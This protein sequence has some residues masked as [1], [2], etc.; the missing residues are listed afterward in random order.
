MK[1][2][3]SILISYLFLMASCVKMEEVHQKYIPDG[4][5]IYRVKPRHVVSYSGNNRAKLTWQLLYPTLVTKCEIRDKDSVLVEIP[6]EYKDSLNLEYI[7]SDLSEKTYTFSLYSLDAEG[8]SSIKSDV[9]VEVFGEKYINTL[10]T[11]TSLKSVWRRADNKETALIS[12][13]ESI[14]S[15][16]SGTTIFYKSITGKEESILVKDNVS[17]IE[18]QGVAT[19]S[20]F[21]LQDLYQPTTNCIDLF[22]APTKEYSVS[23]LPQEGSRTFS[24]VYRVDEKTVYGKLTSASSGT[25]QTKIKYGDKEVIVAPDVNEVTLEDIMPADEISIETILQGG[26]NQSEYSSIIPV[27]NVKDLLAKINMENWEV[28]DFSSHQEGEGDVVYAID[29]QLSTFWHT[30]YSPSQPNYPH[31]IT[32]DMKENIN[33]KAIAIARRNGNDNIA[34][35]FTLELSSDGTNWESVNEFSVNNAIDGIQ[36]VQLETP[37]SGRYFR[38]TGQ[39]SATSNSYMCISEI[40]LFK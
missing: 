27:F 10:K 25:L 20:Y 29:N 19:D 6:V 13:S 36:I 21:K 16:I 33:I 24:S 39:A 18:I 4:E 38:V 11:T 23:E 7:L 17:S 1:V 12:L 31:F 15:K 40:N 2:Y 3:I 30:Q 14:S 37:A 5:T 22:P 26:E 34:S 32:I 35:R 28:I 9:V 8:N